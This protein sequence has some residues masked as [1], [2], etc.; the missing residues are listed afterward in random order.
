MKIQHLATDSH[1][2]TSG[3]KSKLRRQ[4][5]TRTLWASGQRP[6]AHITSHS[7]ASIPCTELQDSWSWPW[8]VVFDEIVIFSSSSF[9][10]FFLFDSSSHF[11]L[12]CG[13][14]VFRNYRHV[15][16][17]WCMRTRMYADLHFYVGWGVWCAGLCDKQGNT[18]KRVHSRLTPNKSAPHEPSYYWLVKLIS[19][20]RWSALFFWE[21]MTHRYTCRRLIK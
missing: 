17:I 14:L 18:R 12:M 19:Y 2:G 20:T 11:L 7:M 4:L 16:C 8:L 9:S 10:P 3:A 13:P 5:R 1:I 15:T 6:K 21:T